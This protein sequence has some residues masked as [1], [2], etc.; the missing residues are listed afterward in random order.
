MKFETDKALSINS[1]RLTIPVCDRWLPN[2]PKERYGKL[3]YWY[4]RTRF[5]DYGG[6]RYD[7]PHRFIRRRAEFNEPI[8]YR[9][10]NLGSFTLEKFFWIGALLPFD[11]IFFDSNP[12]LEVQGEKRD[13]NSP[14]GFE[15]V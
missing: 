13:L 5:G 11:P 15:Y 3:P 4:F 6:S 9:K 8:W 7:L 12:P 2:H 1:D 10:S 14:D